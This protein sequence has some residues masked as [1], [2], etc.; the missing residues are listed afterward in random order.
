MK[1]FMTVEPRR[2][3][4]AMALAVVAVSSGC[5]GPV[6]P[7]EGAREVLTVFYHELG[8]PNWKN[9]DNWA[10]RAP[11]AE[12]YGVR[13]DDEGTVIGLHMPQNGLTGELPGELGMLETL[14]YLN[15]E[16]DSKRTDGF[17]PGRTRQPPE[18]QPIGSGR[19]RT[20]GFDPGRTRQP[21]EPPVLA[22]GGKRA[23]WSASA[24]TDRSPPRAFHLGKDGSL[25]P[26]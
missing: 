24:R 10:T 14:K 2:L 3:Q 26:T 7:V 16:S 8:G 9:N 4:C 11:L 1:P 19:K 23:E 17:D 25:C 5:W 13:V 20:D 15:L 21:P 12:W 6:E 22:S 18:A